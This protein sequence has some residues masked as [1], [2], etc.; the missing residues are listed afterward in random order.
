MSGGKGR[1]SS[2][3]DFLGCLPWEDLHG[4]R[5]WDWP[6]R[7]QDTTGQHMVHSMT[8]S[9]SSLLPFSTGTPAVL[10][11]DPLPTPCSLSLPLGLRNIVFWQITLEAVSW[12]L[13]A[14]AQT[15]LCS[16]Q[17]PAPRL[18]AAFLSSPR[19]MLLLRLT[20]RSVQEPCRGRASAEGPISVCRWP[21]VT[22]PSSH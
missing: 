1:P 19:E 9:P 13:G 3:Q 10:G 5:S 2:S 4:D 16:M 11:R 8:Q 21:G 7:M 22:V 20:L 14:A 17:S 6:P 15:R 12:G 18:G